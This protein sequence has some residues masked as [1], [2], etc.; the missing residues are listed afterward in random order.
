[1][2]KWSPF[3]GNDPAAPTSYDFEPS[4]DE[5]EKKPYRRFRNAAEA[6]ALISADKKDT[7]SVSACAIELQIDAA[8]GAHKYVV[9]IARNGGFGEEASSTVLQLLKETAAQV[10]LWEWADESAD[11][12]LNNPRS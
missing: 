12:M 4:V 8:T 9:T 10:D 1:M 5:G 7:Q 11:G 3:C 6:I 2:E